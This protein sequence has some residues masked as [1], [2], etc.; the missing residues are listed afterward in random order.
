MQ[1]NDALK[2]VKTTLENV[3]IAS[4][5]SLSSNVFRVKLTDNQVRVSFPKTQKIEGK[6]AVTNA[7]DYDP[8]IKQSVKEL[9]NRLD[10]LQAYLP[11]LVPY[12]RIKVTNLKDYPSSIRV[13]NLPDEI[14]VSNMPTLDL[15]VV[16]R[17]LSEVK[18]AIG[19]LPTKYPETKFPE[20]RFPDIPQPLK[21]VSIDNLETLK[22]TDPT[23]Y[24]PVRLTDGE[25]FYEAIGG[26]IAR[27][28]AAFANS[29]GQRT[30]GLVD[31]DHH[32]QVDVV[33]SL[34][35]YQI[36]DKYSDGSTTYTGNESAAGDWYILKVVSGTTGHFRY[37]TARNNPTINTY[38]GAWNNK[39]NLTFGYYSQAFNL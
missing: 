7:K 17:G 5:R 24:V 31:E 27:S 36:N 22:G 15:S 34:D 16:S 28:P 20:I 35:H 38:V 39:A 1:I 14:R 18:Q 32:V 21:R 30:T 10:K 37:A 13:E 25:D 2:F 8:T 4:V 29:S 12:K 19:K 23:S 6:V 33:N 26:A 9:A 11:K 3:A